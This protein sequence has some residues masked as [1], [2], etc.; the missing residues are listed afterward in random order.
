MVVGC[1]DDAW[2]VMPAE[3]ATGFAALLLLPEA[4]LLLLPQVLLRPARDAGRQVFVF[5]RCWG[6]LPAA[7][8]LLPVALWQTANGSD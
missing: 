5:W 1:L 6:A 3:C 8:L 2:R 7:V 4:A